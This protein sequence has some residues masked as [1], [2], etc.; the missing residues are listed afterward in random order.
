[1]QDMARNLICG[2]PPLATS[3]G[4]HADHAGRHDGGV[5]VAVTVIAAQSEM[6]RS[7][8]MGIFG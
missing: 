5:K 4:D 7:T 6:Y 2:P 8:T 3:E 1:M